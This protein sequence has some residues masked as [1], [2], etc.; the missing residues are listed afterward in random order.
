MFHIKISYL[1]SHD[2]L[3]ATKF[4][5]IAFLYWRGVCEDV[6]IS[7]EMCADS[8]AGIDIDIGADMGTDA[9]AD[10]GQNLV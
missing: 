9:L 3:F 7:A 4:Y 10:N 2:D 1:K 5:I 6:D 8:D